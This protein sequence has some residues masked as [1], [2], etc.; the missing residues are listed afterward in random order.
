MPWLAC[1]SRQIHYELA[2]P[3]DGLACVLVNGLTQYLCLARGQ[4]RPDRACYEQVGGELTQ[5]PEGYDHLRSIP[6]QLPRS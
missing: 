5:F 4:S 2:G 1:K 3:E 6:V